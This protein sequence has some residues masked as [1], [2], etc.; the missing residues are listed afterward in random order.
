MVSQNISRQILLYIT[1]HTP[2]DYCRVHCFSL[3]SQLEHLIRLFAAIYADA[4]PDYAMSCLPRHITISGH[5]YLRH[6][7]CCSF[8]FLL[9]H[10]WYQLSIFY[11]TLPHWLRQTASAITLHSQIFS[12]FSFLR[13]QFADATPPGW[14]DFAAADSCAAPYA[15]RYARFSPYAT[16]R[17]ACRF[18]M[19]QP[20]S[21]LLWGFSFRHFSATICFFSQPAIPYFMHLIFSYIYFPYNVFALI[22]SHFIHFC[23]ICFS[24]NTDRDWYFTYISTIFSAKILSYLWLLVTIDISLFIDAIT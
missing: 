8:L 13:H 22:S 2:I 12:H 16:L 11:F 23:R 20:L 19:T 1:G 4:T 7:W 17:Y 24:T 21:L 3:Y 10:W 14:C 9:F 15:S 5:T 18:S 6:Y